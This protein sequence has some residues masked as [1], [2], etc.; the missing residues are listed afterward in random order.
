MYV[1]MTYDVEARRIEKF[2]KLLRKYVGR[3]DLRF[4]LIGWLKD[5]MDF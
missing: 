4:F 2:K 5:R 1:L 3:G